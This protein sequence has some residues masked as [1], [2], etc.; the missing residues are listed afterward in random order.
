M[1]FLSGCGH[2][3]SSLLHSLL[4]VCAH[5]YTHT[6]IRMLYKLNAA[7]TDPVKQENILNTLFSLIINNIHHI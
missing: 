3:P 5:I 2:R 4:M 7:S 1:N 6:H